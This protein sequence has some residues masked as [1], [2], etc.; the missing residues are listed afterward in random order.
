MPYPGFASVDEDYDGM[1]EEVKE[2]SGE[3]R[4]EIEGF[5]NCLLYPCNPPHYEKGKSAESWKAGFLDGIRQCVGG[6]GQEEESR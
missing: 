3:D 2:T 6:N 4:S 5:E 1:Y